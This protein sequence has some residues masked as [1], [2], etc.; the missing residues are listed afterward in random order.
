MDKTK[1]CDTLWD[2]AQKRETAKLKHWKLSK[3]WVIIN[4]WLCDFKTKKSEKCNSLMQ[5]CTTLICTTLTFVSVKSF[6][7]TQIQRLAVFAKFGEISPNLVLKI[8]Y[9]KT[10]ATSCKL[11]KLLKFSLKTVIIYAQPVFYQQLTFIEIL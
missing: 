7:P 11:I 5:C 9:P 4:M 1:Q 10:R 3:I 8:C 6:S 2:T